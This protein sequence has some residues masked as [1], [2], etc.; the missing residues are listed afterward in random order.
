MNPILLPRVRAKK[1]GFEQKLTFFYKLYVVSYNLHSEIQD[2]NSS[3]TINKYVEFGEVLFGTF[4]ALQ[5]H[6]KVATK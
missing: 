2:E 1:A 5:H 6:E 4:L 3:H